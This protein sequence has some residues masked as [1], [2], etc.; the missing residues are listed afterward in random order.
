MPKVRFPGNL[1]KKRRPAG[2]P[3]LSYASVISYFTMNFWVLEPAL[4]K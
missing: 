1:K 3:F 2:S 4:T